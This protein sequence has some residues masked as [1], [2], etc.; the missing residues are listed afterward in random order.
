MVHI[1]KGVSQVIL[2]AIVS[3]G[4]MFQSVR[5]RQVNKSHCETPKKSPWRFETVRGG[6]VDGSGEGEEFRDDTHSC[7]SAG[8]EYGKQKQSGSPGRDQS[9]RELKNKKTSDGCATILNFS[10]TGN[11]WGK[12][13]SSFVTNP[14]RI[15]SEAKRASLQTERGMVCLCGFICTRGCCAMG[16]EG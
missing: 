16:L 9:V 2:G 15:C 11:D 6:E 13:G 14:I 12:G 5:A 8:R 3:L 7:Q 1:Q 10:G 4:K